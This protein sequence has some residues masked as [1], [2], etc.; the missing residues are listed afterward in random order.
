MFDSMF[1]SEADFSGGG[2]FMGGGDIGS[3]FD[4]VEAVPIELTPEQSS[5]L[6][7]DSSYNGLADYSSDYGSTSYE[8]ADHS[9]HLSAFD[10][11]HENTIFNGSPSFECEVNSYGELQEVVNDY[12]NDA[13]F[14]PDNLSQF[15]SAD[16][17]YGNLGS[18]FEVDTD[19]DCGSHASARLE[20]IK[21][22]DEAHERLILKDTDGDGKPD[23]LFGQLDTDGDG[24]SDAYV[25][26]N[27]YDRDEN[28]DNAK[29][30][31]DADGDGRYEKV[32]TGYFNDD[33]TIHIELYDDVTGFGDASLAA[34]V[35]CDPNDPDFFDDSIYV[36]SASDVGVSFK[37]YD[38]LTQFDPA[39]N[40]DFGVTGNPASA[41]EH[42]EPQG[43][44]K[45]CALYSQKF[46]IEEF[47][48]QDIDIE[49][50]TQEAEANGWFSESEGT[51]FLNM[52]KML[53]QYNIPHEVE[54][55]RTIDDLE[56]CLNRG[57]RAIVA[58]D[59]DEIWYDNNHNI[60]VPDR[61]AN[62]AV[63]VI[64]IDR[65]D[66]S[67]PMVIINDS[68]NPNGGCGEMVPL[69]TF[70]DAWEDG[71]CQMIAC[72]PPESVTPNF[73]LA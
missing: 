59:A 23:L 19:F 6:F 2:D 69:E 39:R 73:S 38:D 60:F 8:S 22:W 43:D 26:I 67:N 4:N 32:C 52:D 45:R 15:D 62:H 30:Y 10:Y 50:F 42:W 47:T 29:F 17:P 27:D 33:G 25:K 14:G 56:S 57:G 37:G 16:Q 35:D 44:T 70:K 12:A 31:I 36:D 7:G 28:A 65:S 63:E 64:G 55:N 58:I 72:Y 18:H 1:G 40:D 41:M 46:V 20:D 11:D 49:E 53:D 66:P 5:Q 61:G 51:A 13:N 3:P 9:S 48:G 54:F 68:G 24:L 21:H 71:D 34:S